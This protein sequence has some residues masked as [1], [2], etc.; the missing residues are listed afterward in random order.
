[1]FRL[2]H[3]ILYKLTRWW[4]ILRVGIVIFVIISPIIIFTS[5]IKG[6]LLLRYLCTIIVPWIIIYYNY[7]SVFNYRQSWPYFKQKLTLFFR[8]RVTWIITIVYAL[9]NNNKRKLKKK[10]SFLQYYKNICSK[11]NLLKSMTLWNTMCNLKNYFFIKS[12]R[13]FFKHSFH[14]N[15][16]VS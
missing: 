5:L 7:T 12:S 10:I 14:R 11:N 6:L 16:N 8:T 4:F 1:M 13:R 15:C 2:R 3:Q 9:N